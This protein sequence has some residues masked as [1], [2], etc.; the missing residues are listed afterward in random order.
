MDEFLKVGSRKCELNLFSDNNYYT[1]K[2]KLADRAMQEKIK[3]SVS[4]GGTCLESSL[5]RILETK[6]NLSII[7]T[8]GC[9]SDVKYEQWLKPGQS[10]PQVL[11]VISKDGQENHPL[12]RVGQ[13]IKIP[14]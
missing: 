5:K 3:K 12:A 14:K 11:W 8:D 7:I 2:Y 6:P 4:M 13:T 1:D 10:M 9:Y